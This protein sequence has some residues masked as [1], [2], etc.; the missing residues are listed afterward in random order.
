MSNSLRHARAHE[1]TLSLEVHDGHVRMIVE[2]DGIGFTRGRHQDGEGLKNMAARA[3]K[4]QAH[5][6]V[7]ADPGRGT[8][9]LFEF[10]QERLHA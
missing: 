1:A 2:D 7:T 5:F 10:P 9:I 3:A 8:R 4:L 6:A